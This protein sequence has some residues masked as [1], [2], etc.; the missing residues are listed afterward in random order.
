MPEY[1]ENNKGWNHVQRLGP[2]HIPVSDKDYACTAGPNVKAVKALIAHDKSRVMNPIYRAPPFSDM[3]RPYIS[4][5]A[6]QKEDTGRGMLFCL[7]FGHKP[8]GDTAFHEQAM[9]TAGRPANGRNWD[10]WDG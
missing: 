3:N 8:R 1:I 2:K 9:R 7:C 6:E 5:R 4:I 10:S